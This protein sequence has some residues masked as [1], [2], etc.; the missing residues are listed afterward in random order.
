M[1]QILESWFGK[2]RQKDYYK[3][4]YQEDKLN[5]K[6]KVIFVLKFYKIFL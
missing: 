5:E 1:G 3:E 2:I 4:V 6:K